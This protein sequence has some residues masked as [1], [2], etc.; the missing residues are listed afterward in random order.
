MQHVAHASGQAGA[1][2]V[3]NIS[4]TQPGC[5]AQ[6]AHRSTLKS[7]ACHVSAMLRQPAVQHVQLHALLRGR[8]LA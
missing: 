7:D 1:I 3:K 2:R 8:L 6:L 5:K 4:D